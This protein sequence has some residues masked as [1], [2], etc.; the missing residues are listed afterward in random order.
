VDRARVASNVFF[1]DLPE[2]ELE[3]VAASADEVEFAEGQAITREGDLG[4]CLCVVESGAANVLSDG[5]V[6]AEVGPGDVVGEIAV[7]ASG[8][9]TASV[10]AATPLHA[11]AWFKRDVWALEQTAPE[12]ARRLRA[13]LAGHRA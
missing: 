13:A 5:E 11:L 2:D 1:A 3:A 10:V 12:A 4:H 6:I 9:R 7:L 8:R